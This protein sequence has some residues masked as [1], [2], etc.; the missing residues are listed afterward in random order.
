[1]NKLV[2]L[3]IVVIAMT[4]CST[5]EKATVRPLRPEGWESPTPRPEATTYRAELICVGCSVNSPI[6]IW[7]DVTSGGLVDSVPD[8][9]KV[10]VLNSKIVQGERWYKVRYGSSVGWVDGRFVQ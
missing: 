9:T 4:S 1:M 8:G 7:E 10:T 5:S 2:V 6:A 3:L